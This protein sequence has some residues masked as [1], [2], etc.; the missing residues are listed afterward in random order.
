MKNS[1]ATHLKFSK[2]K[3]SRLKN[4]LKINKITQTYLLKE[5]E[6]EDII[7]IKDFENKSK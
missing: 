7:E 6:F 1:F 3:K 5:F 4:I 2:L